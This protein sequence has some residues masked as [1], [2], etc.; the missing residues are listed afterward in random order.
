MRFASKADRIT[1]VVAGHPRRRISNL[2]TGETISHPGL[3]ARFLNHTFDSE[4]EQVNN[5]WT[6]GQRV[7]V[8]NY[9]LGH[10][11]FDKPGGFF[12]ELVGGESKADILRAAGHP[13][14]EP[15]P[16]RSAE[17]CLFFYPNKETGEIEQCP[18]TIVPGT[19]YCTEHSV[20]VSAADDQGPAP[21]AE[22]TKEDQTAEE[23]EASWRM[24]PVG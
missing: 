6:D 7:I 11:D 4:R 2:E 8:E 12:L 14:A 16:E 22:S 17:R 20:D 3:H 19:E 15:G 21:K 9:L 10:P 18:K 5:G 24:T 1:Y 13:M 23:P